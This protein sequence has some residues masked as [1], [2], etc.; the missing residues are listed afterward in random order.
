M[1]YSG[2]SISG[3]KEVNIFKK[4]CPIPLRDVEKICH[5]ILMKMLPALIEKDIEE[6]GDCI[7]KIQNLGFKK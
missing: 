6:F 1:P 3:N 7:N 4:Y 2:R 5:I